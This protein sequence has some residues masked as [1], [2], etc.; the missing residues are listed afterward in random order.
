MQLSVWTKPEYRRMGVASALKD[1][2]TFVAVNLYDWED[3]QYGDDV[4]L[5]PCIP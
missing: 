4:L 5:K 2:M 3:A 1:Q